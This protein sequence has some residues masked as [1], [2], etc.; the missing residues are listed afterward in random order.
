M[1]LQSYGTSPVLAMWQGYVDTSDAIL[2]TANYLGVFAAFNSVLTRLSQG[3]FLLD[4]RPLY[5]DDQ[6][7]IVRIMLYGNG[8]GSG[9]VYPTIDFEDSLSS[10]PGTVGI[11]FYQL[12]GIPVL[13][14]PIAIFNIVVLDA[15]DGVSNIEGPGGNP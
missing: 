4:C 14:D 1:S 5:M 12:I 3:I 15:T 7:T 13:T 6:D 10:K 11:K 8:N 9:T 2:K